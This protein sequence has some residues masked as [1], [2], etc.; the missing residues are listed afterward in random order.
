M[1]SAEVRRC[2]STSPAAA[3]S[4]LGAV[5][6]VAPPGRP[7][8]RAATE[9]ETLHRAV[10]AGLAARELARI[11]VPFGPVMHSR[12]ELLEARGFVPRGQR[13]EELVV[14]EGRRDG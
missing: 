10:R 1:P 13:H 7:P 3:P 5:L 2:P 4:P 12:V 14:V 6:S 8:S 11:T 9:V